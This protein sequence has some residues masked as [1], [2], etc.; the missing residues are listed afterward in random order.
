MTTFRQL[1]QERSADPRHKETPDPSRHEIAR[2]PRF[3]D[4][5]RSFI[6]GE[7]SMHA[8]EL[9]ME[10]FDEADDF[11]FEE[12]EPDLIS[13]YEAVVLAEEMKESLDGEPDTEEEE[14]PEPVPVATPPSTPEDHP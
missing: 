9:D 11:E 2:M 7:L 1:Q 4:Q 12:D 5:I 3:R 13:K 8:Q 6:R 14:T 10:S